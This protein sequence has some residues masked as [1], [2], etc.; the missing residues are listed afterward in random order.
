MHTHSAYIPNQAGLPIGLS[1]E[2]WFH[3]FLP[4][5]FGSPFHPFPL[6][7]IFFPSF[8]HV[9]LPSRLG[10]SSLLSFARTLVQPLVCT[11]TS[12]STSSP[13]FRLPRFDNEVGFI[14][15]PCALG[16]S[17]SQPRTLLFGLVRFSYL[18]LFVLAARTHG[19]PSQ[20]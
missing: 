15:C 7:H 2:V 3:R 1:I 6:T 17:S 10:I 13:G 11:C 14:V 19:H 12:T 16:S 4:P 9:F 5:P 20:P 8:L 18:H